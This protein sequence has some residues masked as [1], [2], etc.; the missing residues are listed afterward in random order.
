MAD[1]HSVYD[2]IFQAAG[3]EWNIDPLVLKAMSMQESPK[4]DPRAVSPAGA[5]GLMQIMPDTARRLGVTNPFDP[6]E[7]IFGAAKYMN[8][9]LDKEGSLEGA[10]LNYHGGDGWRQKF[11]RE[12]RDYVPAV[13]GHYK[14]LLAAQAQQRPAPPDAAAAAGNPDIDPR[15]GL[16]DPAGT[17]RQAAQEAR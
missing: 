17:L 6:V 12:S 3:E 8:Q 11:G 16:V 9:A 15:T 10:L 2:P 1:R 14:G 13:A 5:L 4:G 7:S